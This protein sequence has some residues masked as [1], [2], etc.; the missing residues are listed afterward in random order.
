MKPLEYSHV[1]VIESLRAG[2]Q[3]TGTSLYNDIIVRRM[4][5]RGLDGQYNLFSVSTKI[6]FFQA[7]EAIRQKVI[8]ELAN[9]VIHFE[10]H[11][12]ENG[13]QTN[14]GDDISWDE[15]QFSLLQINAISGNNVLISMATC[16][17]AYIFK[18]INP[19]AWTPFWGC[20]GPFEV[21]QGDEILENY[22]AFYNEFLQSD[23]LNAAEAA[24]RAA[25]L[26]GQFKFRFNNTEWVFQTAYK[27]YEIVYFTPDILDERVEAA[28]Q[29]C[30][31]Q[32]QFETWSDE[33]IRNYTRHLIVD[34]N[35][36]FRK[37]IMRKFFLLEKFPE[38]AQYYNLD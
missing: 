26:N 9:P 19:S 18:S 5:Q 25:N 12:D 34:Q 36:F 27:N 24:L 1:F 37:Q 35:A 14:N 15:L 11:G 30:R 22:T 21:V 20:V 4:Q 31:P 32:V 16:K 13:L 8:F 33:M 38:H 3:K 23:D 2:E 7:L 28:F 10:L 6:E 17:G 29:Q